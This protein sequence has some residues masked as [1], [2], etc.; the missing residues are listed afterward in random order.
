MSFRFLLLVLL[1]A[2]P[3]LAHAQ[4]APAPSL[5]AQGLFP[6]ALPWDD[7]APGPTDVSF[8][9]TAPAG[10]NGFLSAS[11]EN[12]VDERGQVVRLWG[13]N[14]NFGG[15]FPDHDQAAKIAA[16]LAKFGFNAVRFHH[17]DGLP[18]PG[19]LW[20]AN[21]NGKLLWPNEFDPAQFERLDFFIAELIKRGV[22]ID[23]NL[24]VARKATERDGFLD[25]AKL[26]EKDKGI[27]YFDARLDE[28]NRDFARHLL[29]H[30]NPYT[31]RAYNAEPGGVRGR[32]G[33]RI[34]PLARVAGRQIGRL[35]AD[36]R[37]IAAVGLERLGAREI[38]PR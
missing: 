27:P 6:F 15:A 30:V 20:K 23:F 8:L 5:S 38:W 17:I 19:G 33:Q 1:C 37:R 22:Y 9:N 35:A 31:A 14:L 25:A 29:T 11:G 16:R 7:G 36:L 13:V 18:A 34:E 24:H 32:G 28:R 12:F 4:T 3:I 2:F 21:A 26:P 10:V